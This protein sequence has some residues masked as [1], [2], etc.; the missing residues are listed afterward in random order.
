MDATPEFI[1]ELLSKAGLGKLEESNH[2]GHGELNNSYMVRVGSERYC[3]RVAKYNFK[4]ALARE[5]DA[6][7]RL[8]VGIAPRLVY[9]NPDEAIDGH[10]WIIESF[11]PGTTPT[12]LNLAQFKSMGKKLARV[13]AIVAPPKDVVDPGEVTGVRTHLWDHITWASRSFY[14]E[15][16]ILHALPDQRLSDLARRA[17]TWLDEREKSIRIPEQKSL[18]HKDITPSNVLVHD[19]ECFLIDWELR[20]FGDPMSDFGTG[21]WDFDLNQGKWRIALNDDEKH[22]LYEGYKDAGGSI[23]EERITVWTTLDKLGVLMYLCYRI[24]EPAHDATPEHQEQ[25]KQDFEAT[26]ASVQSVLAS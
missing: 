2:L 24:H 13:H 12:R 15:D 11:L 18:L 17:K 21:F 8:P 5:A 23:D 9:F 4:T 19:N 25:Y 16:T 6:I 3:L 10:L 26:Y 1:Q 7:S 14:S 22:A 20:G